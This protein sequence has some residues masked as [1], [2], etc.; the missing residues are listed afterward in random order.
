MG[1][2]EMNPDTIQTVLRQ[3]GMDQARQADLLRIAVPKTLP[4][5][6]FFV[7]NG[8]TP[9][10]FA[11][12][13]TGLCRYFYLTEQGSELTKGIIRPADLLI[14]YSALLHGQPAQYSIEALEESDILEINWQ[15]W[16]RLQAGN[17]F[18]DKF[19]IAML[20]KA[21][22]LKEK[23]ERELLLC[24]ARE[25]YEIFLQEFGTPEGRLKQHIIASYLGIQ[26]ESLSR[27]RK[28]IRQADSKH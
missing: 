13:L 27:I 26:K 18:W 3:M 15:D 23:R 6:S 16:L 4:K 28:N 20:Q 2:S 7:Q 1:T 8:Q 5:G 21:Y 12:L 17:P 11:I 14:A 19:V 25:R 22:C 9:H 10:T 24:S